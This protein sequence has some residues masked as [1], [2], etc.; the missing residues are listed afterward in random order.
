M[1][2]TDVVDLLTCMF[3]TLNLN[4]TFD[5]QDMHHYKLIKKQRSDSTKM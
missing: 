1:T 5:N 3:I 4:E 2:M